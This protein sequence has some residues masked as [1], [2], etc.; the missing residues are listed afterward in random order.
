MS[1]FNSI[2]DVRTVVFIPFSLSL[3]D[4]LLSLADFAG[5]RVGLPLL[6]LCL[7]TDNPVADG[8]LLAVVVDTYFV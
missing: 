1:L 3:A 5:V 7:F 4:F 2:A 8:A 6:S